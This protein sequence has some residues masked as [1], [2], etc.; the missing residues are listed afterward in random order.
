[1]ICQITLQ[2]YGM[3]KFKKVLYRL[4]TDAA[5]YGLILF[6]L[7]TGWL[8]GPGGIPL[9]LGGLGLLAIHNRWAQRI[10]HIAK[11]HGTQLVRYIFPENPYIK[12]L[13]DMLA[14]SLVISA[15]VIVNTKITYTTVA[16]AISLTAL[17]V[18]DFLYNRNRWNKIKNRLK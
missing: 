15:V 17:G 2:L 12:A 14:I 1:M 16:F 8:P 6:G 10:L 4:G 18:A 5:G 9:I 13:H 7:L 3:Q 11:T